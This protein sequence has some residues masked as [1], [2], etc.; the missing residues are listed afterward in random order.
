MSTKKDAYTPSPTT[1]H[2]SQKS[3]GMPKPFVPSRKPRFVWLK[4]LARSAPPPPNTADMSDE[5]DQMLHAATELMQ[6]ALRAGTAVEI[7]APNNNTERRFWAARVLD[8]DAE[9]FW[10]E[11]EGAECETGWC[12]RDAFLKSWRFP[13]AD[14]ADAGRHFTYSNVRR[15]L[16]SR[17]PPSKRGTATP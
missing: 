17:A 6:L 8:A 1:P 11:Y 2:I 14:E 3:A 10:Y 7:Y 9:G 12:T 15:I 13:L 16:R 4:L 5:V